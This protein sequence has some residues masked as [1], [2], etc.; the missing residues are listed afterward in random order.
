MK[1]A[2]KIL[3]VMFVAILLL[4]TY[5]IVGA[6]QVTLKVFSLGTG[7]DSDQ[8]NARSYAKEDAESKIIC[9]GDLQGVR[10]VISGCSNSGDNDSQNWTCLATSTAQC[11]MGH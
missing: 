10:T 6:K 5:E 2:R 7:N 4:V 1:N 11:V 8:N 3:S 9:V